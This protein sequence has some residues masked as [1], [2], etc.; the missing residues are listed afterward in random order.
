MIKKIGAAVFCFAAVIALSGCSHITV[1]RTQELKE[2]QDRVDT[3]H[4]KNINLHTK[5]HEKQEK[6][7]EQM[8]TTSE[9]L[10]IMR[11]EQQ[12]HFT[13]LDR[14]ISAVEN[15][16]F[17][18]QSQ[19]SNLKQ[20]TAEV[21]RRLEQQIANAEE[22]ANLRKLQLEKLF[23]IAMGDFNAGRYDLAI[24]GFRDL[25]T[26]FPE[27]AEAPEAE[28]WIAESYFAKRDFETAE[29]AYFEFVKK[30]ADGPRYCVALYKLGLTYGHQNKM[31]SREMVWRNLLN[32]CADSPEAQ[33]VQ[34]Q[35]ES[36]AAA[37]Q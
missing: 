3:L 26:Q 22:A 1:L 25:A 20:S 5:L 34:A 12:M 23:E 13:N 7:D 28:Y 9:M 6:L 37:G 15:N 19:L 27:S 32:R 33:A 21:S 14:K 18:N 24:G 11:A 30:H 4:S 10:R 8:K 17:E 2:I 16:I 31:R 29:K 35:L 36:E